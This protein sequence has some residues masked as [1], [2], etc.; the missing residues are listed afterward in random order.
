MTLALITLVPVFL[1]ALWAFF[2]FSPQ[3]DDRHRIT[4]FNLGVVIFGVAVCGFA[5]LKVHSGMSAGPD[6]AWWPIISMLYSLVLFPL[7][8]GI[9][10]VVRNFVVFRTGRSRRDA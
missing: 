4:R 2:R 8:L 6:K 7:V 9:G 5:T 10:G 1:L 3:A